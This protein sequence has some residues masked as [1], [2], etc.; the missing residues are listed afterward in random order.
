MDH[1]TPIAF[2]PVVSLSL[3]IEGSKIAK[4]LSFSMCSYFHTYC[5]KVRKK[6]PI[7]IKCNSEQIKKKEAW[8]TVNE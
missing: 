6:K 4:Y 8:Y 2:P 1:A 3:K 5:I 7:Q